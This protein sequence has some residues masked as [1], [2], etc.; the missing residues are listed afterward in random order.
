[1]VCWGIGMGAHE[2][3]MRAAV[4]N[5]VP[6]ERRGSA[7]GLFNGAYGVFWFVGSAVMGVLYQ[8]SIVWAVIFAVVLQLAAIP[9]FLLVRRPGQQSPIA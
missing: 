7:Y 8:N 3:V 2:S 4:A 5:F 9:I 6:A 1:M